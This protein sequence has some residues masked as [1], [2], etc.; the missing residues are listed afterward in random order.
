MNPSHLQHPQPMHGEG[1]LRRV[2]VLAPL[3]LAGWALATS[4]S[5]FAA[6]GEDLIS[7]DRPDFVESSLTVG[8]GRAQIETSLG[9]ERNEGFHHSPH[10]W[11]TPTLLRVGVGESWEA[12]LE[13]EGWVSVRGEGNRESGMSEVA[14]GAKYH[15]APAGPWGASSA[16]LMHVDLPTGDPAFQGR[17]A[18]PSLRWTAEWEVGERGSLGVM[19]GVIWNTDDEGDRYLGELFGI[20]YAYAWT[21]RFRSFAE[22]AADGLGG[23]DGSQKQLTLDTGVAWVVTPDVQVDAATYIGLN[24][25]APDVALTLGLSC[26]W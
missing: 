19:P 11:A 15:L 20:T 25:N 24:D 3:L 22:F 26:R 23:D 17:G 9:Y 6:E 7:T 4:S 2:S 21:G 12:R 18:R 13:T 1:D 5:A 10:E 14:L 16:V 8:A